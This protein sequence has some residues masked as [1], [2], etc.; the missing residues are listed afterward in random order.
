MGVGLVQS[1]RKPPAQ[2]VC[3]SSP[4]AVQLS[5]REEDRGDEEGFVFFRRAPH[6]PALSARLTRSDAG[7]GNIH[8]ETAGILLH[9][10][11]V[12]CDLWQL[13]DWLRPLPLALQP[14][15]ASLLL[16]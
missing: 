3:V 6:P 16:L 10:H 13:T 1:S 14:N 7:S 9:Q 2:G 11:T 15:H 8:R 4:K 12:T 5:E